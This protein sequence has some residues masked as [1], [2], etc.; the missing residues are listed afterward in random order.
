MGKYLKKAISPQVL[1]HAWVY[2]RNDR[3]AWQRGLSVED[4]QR[5]LIRYV[6][7]VSDLIVAGKYR[8][9]RMRCHE[10]DKADGSKRLICASFVRNKLVQ[11]AILTVLEPLG[12][13]IFHESSFGSL[14]IF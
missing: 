12:E 9:D 10:V 3:G 7:E 14:A 4:M 8:T 1:N 5:N 13:A 2:L 11:R 6:G